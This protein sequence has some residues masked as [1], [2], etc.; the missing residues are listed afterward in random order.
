[1]DT[2]NHAKIIQELIAVAPYIPMFYDEP[3]SVAISDRVRFVYNQPCPEIPVKA[4]LGNP[5]PA[6]STCSMVVNNGERIVREVPPTVYGI[7]FKSYAI[8]LRGED[9]TIEG[10]LLIAKSIEK[11]KKV[12]SSMTELVDEVQQ[13]SDTTITVSTEAQ[14]S[15]QFIY[16]ITELIGGLAEETEKMNSILGFINKISNSTKILGL[17]AL[18]EAARA[19]EAGKGFSVVAKEI[20]KMSNNTTD[21]AKEISRMLEGVKEQLDRI[22]EK[23]SRQQALLAVRQVLWRILLL[24][25]RTYMQILMFWKITYRSFNNKIY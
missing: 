13:V 22:N 2:Q 9:G 11:I 4:D 7:P 3:V 15:S 24:Q 6:D 23:D 16:E 17:N 1:M 18:I 14:E 5:F 20:E 8:P 10:C 12:K 21:A 19:G 25:L